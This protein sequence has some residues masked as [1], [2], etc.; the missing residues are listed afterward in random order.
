MKIRHL[1]AIILLIQV[2][3]AYAQLQE[4]EPPQSELDKWDWVQ[5]TSGEWLKGEIIVLYGDTLEFDSDILDD[6][7][8]DWSD[9]SQVRSAKP[10]KVRTAGQ[11]DKQGQLLIH[12]DVV[13]LNG[14]D[15]FDRS[16]LLTVTSGEELERRYWS[17]KYLLGANI[18]SGNSDQVDVTSNL[19][20]QRRTVANRVVIKHMMNFSESTDKTTDQKVSTAKDQRGNIAWDHFLSDR[21]F[22]RPIFG[23]YQKDDFK[24]IES[25][26]TIGSGAGYQIFDEAWVEWRLI[27]GPAYQETRYITVLPE[28]SEKEKTPAFTGVSSF[29]I[30][31]TSDLELY[32]DYT[33]YF[34]NDKSGRYLH[35]M[36][37][38]LNMEVTSLLD[39]DVSLVW[40][41]TDNPKPDDLGIYPEKND[42]RLIVS[43]G[44]DY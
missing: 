14:V 2:A 27:V 40:D 5:L 17:I 37:T 30:D 31:I 9:V 11:I 34:V 32:H 43:F 13:T 12:D 44:L 16:Q 3:T 21:F 8:L 28:E 35:H 24:N 26:Y 29:N 18:R 23:E 15:S 42:Y 22:L 4:F 38:G 6:L 7:N 1:I 36:V 10:M 39:F 19:D 33:F 25:K 41:R 20:V